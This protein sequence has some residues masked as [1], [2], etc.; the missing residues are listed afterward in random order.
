MAPAYQAADALVHPTLE[1][2]YGMVVLEAM[3]HGLP[4]VVSGA[5]FSGIA[6]DL[7]DGV[8]ALLLKDPRNVQTLAAAIARLQSDAGF[9]EQLSRNAAMFA[10]EHTWVKAASA[11]ALMVQNMAELR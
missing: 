8:N 2:S 3:A 6:Q 4:V 11:Y 10:A 5:P 7:T 1:D 9:S